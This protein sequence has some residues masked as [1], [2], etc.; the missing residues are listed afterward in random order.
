MHGNVWEMCQDFFDVS[1]Y[2]QLGPGI[3]ESPTG[4]ATCQFHVNGG[5]GFNAPAL[6]ARTASR[7]PGDGPRSNLGF[8]PVIAVES[9]RAM[10]TRRQMT[11]K[12]ADPDRPAVNPQK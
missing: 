12:P 2:A 11:Q 10:L 7:R 5:G 4:P 3:I 1:D 9:V 8:R 6:Q